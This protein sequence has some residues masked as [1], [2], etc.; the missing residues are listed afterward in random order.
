MRGRERGVTLLVTMLLLI[1]VLLLGASAANMA[2]LAEKSARAERDHLIAF[3]AAE[4]AL[5]DAENDIEGHGTAPARADQFALDDD[6]KAPEIPWCDAV[7]ASAWELGL[8]AA[9]KDGDGAAGAPAWLALDLSAGAGVPFGTF[10][11]AGMETGEGAQPFQRPRYLVERLAQAGADGRPTYYY[12]VTAI[13]FGSRAG[14]EV[15]LQT[16]YQRREDGGDGRQS[17]R[18]IASWRELHAAARR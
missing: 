14:H 18:E 10:T 5:M 9:A 4:D 8:C 17:W 15:V 13:G 11:G 16:R 2:V 1:G 6:G 12:R 7:A 3:E